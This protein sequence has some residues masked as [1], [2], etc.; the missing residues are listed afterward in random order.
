MSTEK[1]FS[2]IPS[3]CEPAE[4][5]PKLVGIDVLAERSGYKAGSI[6]NMVSQ[7]RSIG[8][9]ALRVSGRLRW[10]IEDVERWLA[11]ELDGLRVGVAAEAAE[12]AATAGA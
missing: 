4:G 3:Q 2:Q 9:L 11:G 10:R 5:L 7:G 12:A 6:R 8:A 1:L